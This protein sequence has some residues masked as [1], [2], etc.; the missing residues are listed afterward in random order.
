MSDLD[1]QV[2]VEER[3]KLLQLLPGSLAQSDAPRD[4]PSWDRG[5]VKAFSVRIPY[6][7]L[8][9]RGLRCPFAKVI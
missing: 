7:R 4:H 6:N 1:P 8:N 3:E 5:S 2:N 9:D